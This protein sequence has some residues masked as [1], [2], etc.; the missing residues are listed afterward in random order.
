MSTSRAEL[1]DRLA[2]LERL[3][4]IANRR[5]RQTELSSQLNDPTIWAQPEKAGKLNQELKQLSDI[6]VAFDDVNDLLAVAGDDEL[7]EVAT[8]LERL[9][10]QA[11]L[12]GEHDTNPAVLT[13]FA[14]AGGTD[15]QDWAEMLLRMYVR[16]AE[17]RSWRTQLVE[18]S[19]GEEAGLKK[20]TIIVEGDRAFGWL[21]GEAG[22]HRLV[23]LSPFNAKNLRQ[24]SFALVDIIPEVEQE[25]T[26]HIEPDDL[27][28]DVFRSG[29]HGG[30]GVNTTDS[31]V[32]VTHLPTN[33]V[34]SVQNERSQLQNKATAMKILESKLLLLQEVK[35]DEER[36]AIRGEIP[37]AAWGNQIRNYVLHPY[38]LV[39]DVRTGV[40]TSD[41]AA[42]LNGELDQFLEAELRLSKPN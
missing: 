20:A 37:Q 35:N 41:T 29:G 6:L 26:V 24:T 14:G 11:L 30:Q 15:A 10:S 23:R 13:I 42:V 31:A 4:Q 33:I 1:T 27:R 22:V 40:E 39:K 18:E 3:L 7:G 9:E 36:A 12:A 17:R 25:H 8:E 16:L 28:I 2:A 38:N 34:V 19:H 21:K 32:R 5:A